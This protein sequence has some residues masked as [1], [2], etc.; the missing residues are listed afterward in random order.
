MFSILLRFAIFVLAH[1]LGYGDGGQPLYVRR[2]GGS[3]P[4]TSPNAN[5]IV[6]NAERP[7]FLWGV[8][9]AAYQIEGAANSRGENIWDAFSR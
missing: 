8:A 1:R 9:T 4:L 5:M 3:K 6:A 2:G 7:P